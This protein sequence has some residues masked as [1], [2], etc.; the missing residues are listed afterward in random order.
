M[1]QEQMS[2]IHSNSLSQ[3]TLSTR[4]SST[5]EISFFFSFRNTMSGSDGKFSSKNRSKLH[6][7][8]ECTIDSPRN[9]DKNNYLISY[10][11]LLVLQKIWANGIP[12]PSFPSFFV[13]IRLVK[14]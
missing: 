14:Y 1:D 8:R 5:Q 6:V 10:I 3:V 13:Y 4:L 12:K 11:F 2:Q 9:L 7:N